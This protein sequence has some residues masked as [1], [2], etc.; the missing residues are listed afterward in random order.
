MIAM[1]KKIAMCGKKRRK[2]RNKRD[3]NNN[4]LQGKKKHGSER[5][6]APMP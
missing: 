1:I 4:N 6:E 5:K 2:Q 3:K